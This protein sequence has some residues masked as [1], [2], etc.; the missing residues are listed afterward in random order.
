MVQKWVGWRVQKLREKFSYEQSLK[1]SRLHIVEGLL[2][3]I[4]KIDSIIKRIRSSKDKSEAKSSL[5]TKPFNFSERQAEAILDMRL[6]QLSNL[7]SSDLE[8]ER[9]SLETRITDLK[10]LTQ[11]GP[12]GEKARKNHLV[13]EVTSLGKIYGKGRRSPLIKIVESPVQLT[14]KKSSPKVFS[15]KPRFMKV[16]S[17]KGTVEQAKGPR[18]ALVLDSK[19][20]VILMTEDGLLRK[21]PSNFKG[22]I[23][24]SYSP[25]TLAKREAD[26]S[27]RKYLIVFEVESQVRCIVLN[28][29][30]L[31]KSTSK[32]KRW[33]MEGSRLIH[34][35]ENPYTVEWVSKRRKPLKLD[36]TQKSGKP[37]SRGVKIGSAE[38]IVNLK[39]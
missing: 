13:K 3:A 16:D 18:G 34:F 9:I 25:V 5:M 30:D 37:A 38:E 19:D 21:V 33:L 26:V 15:P 1:E 2:L 24:S 22:A 27:Q 20:K 23:S 7:D 36:L 28:G 8:E 39:G 29:I 6:R 10:E 35:S 12:E 4:G 31:C 32:G 11:E 14:E 17:K